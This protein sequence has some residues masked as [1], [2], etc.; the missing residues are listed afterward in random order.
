MWKSRLLT[1]LAMTDTGAFAMGLDKEQL[2]EI[3]W[4]RKGNKT[5]GLLLST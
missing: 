3:G 5:G 4:L 2:E 1:T